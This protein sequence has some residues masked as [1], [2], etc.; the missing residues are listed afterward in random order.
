MREDARKLTSLQGNFFEICELSSQYRVVKGFI[1]PWHRAMPGEPGTTIHTCILAVGRAS[2]TTIP[3][4]LHE[5]LSASKRLNSINHNSYR[6]GWHRIGLSVVFDL[7]RIHMHME[8]TIPS[9][10][11]SS[12]KTSFNI[13]SLYAPVYLLRT[14]ISPASTSITATE[15]HYWWN[16]ESDWGPDLVNNVSRNKNR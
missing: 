4:R 3:Y 13:T 15:W 1:H 7:F 2:S 12:T 6:V 11:F 8:S 9:R 5:L 14:H 16:L 10:N